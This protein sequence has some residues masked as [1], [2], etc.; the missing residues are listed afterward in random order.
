[1]VE[2][3][4]RSCRLISERNICPKCKS[5]DLSEDFS[6]FAVIIDPGKSTIAKI[7]NIKEKGRYAIRIR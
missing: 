1:M 3:A 5:T 6:G 2:K 7:M 4:C